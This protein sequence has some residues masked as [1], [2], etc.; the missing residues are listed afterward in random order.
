MKVAARIGE[1]LRREIRKRRTPKGGRRLAHHTPLLK[2]PVWWRRAV[3]PSLPWVVLEHLE[4]YFFLLFPRSRSPV[5]LIVLTRSCSC[6]WG[7]LPPLVWCVRFVYLLKPPNGRV[8]RRID[9]R[10]NGGRRASGNPSSCHDI[11]EGNPSANTD[12]STDRGALRGTTYKCW[13]LGALGVQ[14][15][16]SHPGPGS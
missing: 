1:R 16:A 2:I 7:L 15:S 3:L 9:R 6:R 8:G 11:P 10:T 14:S 13:K 4:V 12:P 5:S